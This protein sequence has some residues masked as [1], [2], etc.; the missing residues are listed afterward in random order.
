MVIVDHNKNIQRIIDVIKDD[1]SI[2]DNGE[3]VGKLR[4]VKFG[5]PN[6]KV[7][8]S[9]A[10]MPYVY[11]TTKESI[12]RSSYPYGVTTNNNIP[13]VTV[14]YKISVVTSSKIKTQESEKLAYNLLKDLRT[15]LT[16]DPTFKTTDVTPVD[17]IFTRSVLNQVPWE[18]DTIGQLV[19]TIDF[20]LLAT[21]GSIG[22]IIISSV[23]D[24]DSI[25][26]ISEAPDT[27]VEGFAPQFDTALIIQGYAPTGSQRSK[28]IEID[29]INSI[30]EE[31]R[32]LKLSR[33]PFSL[34]TT[35]IDG[36]TTVHN[37]ILSQLT[38]NIARIDNI[39]TDLLQFLIIP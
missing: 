26:I 9:F 17:P 1:D 25:E 10:P 22:T 20:I 13:Q 38:S 31:L 24:G 3:T 15:T 6:N 28:S 2:F 32:T 8:E 36:T 39:K 4:A 11:I 37:A 18:Q 30:T 12:Q 34:T 7:K 27:D 19:T 21:I 33:R 5:N 16:A 29:H 14:E 23:N 35:D